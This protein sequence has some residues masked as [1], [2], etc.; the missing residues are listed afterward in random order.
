MT[1][2]PTLLVTGGTRGLGLGCARHMAKAGWN[3]ALADISD[4]AVRVYR[5]AES[6]EKVLA[7]L[8][9]SSAQTGFYPADLSD[10]SH[11][12]H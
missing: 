7:E 9:A 10:E 2:R 11:T 5:E 4:K 8:A 12:M 6:V 1:D 3:I